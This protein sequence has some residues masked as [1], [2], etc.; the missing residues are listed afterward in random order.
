MNRIITLSFT[1][2][3]KTSNFSHSFHSGASLIRQLILPTKRPG[4]FSVGAMPVSISNLAMLGAGDVGNNGLHTQSQNQI[5]KFYKNFVRY[6]K[7]T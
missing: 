2:E 5:S 6:Y 3:T 4:D 7:T 1:S